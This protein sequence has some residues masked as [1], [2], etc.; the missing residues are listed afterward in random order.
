[1]RTMTGGERTGRKNPEG[2]GEPRAD[3][4]KS[5]GCEVGELIAM[6]G[7]P[8]TLR[9]LDVLVTNAGTPMRFTTLQ[10]RLHLSPKTLA[11]RLRTLVEAGFLTRRS[12]NEIPPRVE[13]EVT[14]KATD[15]GELFRMLGRWAQDHTMTAVPTVSV[16][17]R[18]RPPVAA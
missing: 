16:V 14:P 8:H 6:L 13:Y 12:Y 15:L 2:R 18:V 17:G 7:Q 10:D 1:M 11:Q 4:P 9:L 3:R 5:R